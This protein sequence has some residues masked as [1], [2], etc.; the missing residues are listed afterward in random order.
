MRLTLH[1]DY[2]LRTLIYLG[3]H[4]DHLTFIREVVGVYG[5]SENHLV[6]I[7][8]RL[9]QAGFFKTVR[10]RNG[11]LRLGQ[12]AASILIDDVVCHTEEDMAPVGCMQ[13]ARIDAKSCIL[14]DCCS[15]RGVLGKALDPFIAVLDHYT[16]ADVITD[17]ERLRLRLPTMM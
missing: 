8:H 1:T 16:L 17:N 11:G 13:H 2:A 12:P 6:K 4:T 5:I 7:I 15:L 10:G 9:G 3:I 14:A